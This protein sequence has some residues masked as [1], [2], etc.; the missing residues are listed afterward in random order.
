MADND[1]HTDMRPPDVDEDIR[2]PTFELYRHTI[3][4]G[5]NLGSTVS[6]L[7]APPYLFYKGVRTPMELLRRTAGITAKGMVRGLHSILQYCHL[8]LWLVWNLLTRPVCCGV[9]LWCGI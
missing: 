4:R 9:N 6:M 5:A 2:H 1:H 3:L 7:V 8:P